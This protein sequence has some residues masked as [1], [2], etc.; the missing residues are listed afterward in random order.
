[1]LACA[2][3]SPVRGPTP[4]RSP[5]YLRRSQ[6]Q[7]ARSASR[8]VCCKTPEIRSSPE[9]SF[10]S[11]SR[12]LAQSGVPSPTLPRTCSASAIVTE[13]KSAFFSTIS[14]HRTLWSVLAL[15]L[16]PLT[17]VCSPQDGL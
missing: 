15:P 4:A 13:T 17:E 1:M 6:S 11:P 5:S 10:S 8:R 2:D 12:P 7:P 14:R 3:L 16:Q 9:N